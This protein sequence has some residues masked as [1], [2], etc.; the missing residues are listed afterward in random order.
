[1]ITR[2]Q[3]LKI[4]KLA[5]LELS[6]AEIENFTG[7]LGSIL[8]FTEQLNQLDTSAVEPTCF[9]APSHDPLREDSEKPSLPR[10]EVLQNGPKVKK[11]RKSTRLNS[12]HH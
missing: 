10:E 5:R 9:V 12:S 6:E 3:V 11:D 4:A 2:E 7:Q 8:D 1:M